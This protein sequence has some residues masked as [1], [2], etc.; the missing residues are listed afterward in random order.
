MDVNMSFS[1]GK[2][3]AK[4]RKEVSSTFRSWSMLFLHIQLFINPRANHAEV[5]PGL[6]LDFMER[7]GTWATWR[8]ETFGAVKPWTNA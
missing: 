1:S 6:V 4:L 8:P 2:A 3:A 5:Y 7:N